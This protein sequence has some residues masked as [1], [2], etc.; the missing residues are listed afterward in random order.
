MLI[1]LYLSTRTGLDFLNVPVTRKT[2]LAVEAA[3][4]ENRR[5]I[6]EYVDEPF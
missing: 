4:G 5:K 3:Q 2:L 6:P 1:W